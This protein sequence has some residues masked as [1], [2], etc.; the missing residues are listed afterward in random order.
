MQRCK[1]K[2]ASWGATYWYQCLA[3]T[4]GFQKMNYFFTQKREKNVQ[5][6]LSILNPNFSENAF[7]VEMWAK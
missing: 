6:S 3:V 4:P 1:K 2:K 5:T 7:L